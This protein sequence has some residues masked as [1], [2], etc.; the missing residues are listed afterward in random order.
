MT[1]SSYASTAVPPK[2]IDLGT[3]DFGNDFGVNMFDEPKNVEEPLP[4]MP[5]FSGFHRT[6]G[7]EKY[8]DRVYGLLM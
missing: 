2:K 6:V 3:N 8:E 7:L 5:S 4:P 1:T